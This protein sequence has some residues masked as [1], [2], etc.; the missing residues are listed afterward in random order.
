MK[1]SGFHLHMVLVVGLICVIVY[2]FY[3]SKDIVTLDKE[4]RSLKG[5]LDSIEMYMA[6]QAQKEKIKYERPT[7]VSVST[8]NVHVEHS[9]QDTTIMTDNNDNTDV[10]DDDDN[11][12]VDTQKIQEMLNNIQDTEQTL[13]EEKK[14][15]EDVVNNTTEVVEEV[16]EEVATSVTEDTENQP[17]QK[18]DDFLKDL[19]LQELRNLCRENGLSTKGNK[20]QLYNRLVEFTNT[21]V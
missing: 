10:N 3:I 11:V 2:A 8:D 5:K 13:D 18:G 17:R 20:D 9:I 4:V 12:S 15:E 6:N 16:V 7:Q 19:T 21:S 14:T 1:F